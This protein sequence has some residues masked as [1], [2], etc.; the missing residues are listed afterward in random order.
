MVKKNKNNLSICHGN[1]IQYH[2]KH[3]CKRWVFH[4]KKVKNTHNAA[5]HMC[6]ARKTNRQSLEVYFDDRCQFSVVKF[7]SDSVQV[8]DLGSSKKGRSLKKKIQ[9]RWE[10]GIVKGEG[11]R[12][13]LSVT[14]P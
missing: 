4:S 6:T 8:C 13:L 3:P 2:L 9:S 1:P 14:A 12:C 5:A 11:S 10:E 7:R